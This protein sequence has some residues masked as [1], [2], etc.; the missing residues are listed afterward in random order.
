MFFENIDFLEFL[1][2]SPLPAHISWHFR[3]VKILVRIG[4]TV[5][6]KNPKG[7]VA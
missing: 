6:A 3:K 1:G 7:Q 4:A 2:I 5:I